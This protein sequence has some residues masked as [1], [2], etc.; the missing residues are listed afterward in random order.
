MA[1]MEPSVA[2]TGNVPGSRPAGASEGPA[3]IP[4]D[5][6]GGALIEI[7]RLPELRGAIAAW[8]VNQRLGSSTRNCKV[9]A[10]SLG[11]STGITSRLS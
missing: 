5:T 9:S 8:P 4:I 3:I 10:W 7:A 1:S 11:F 6:G 2:V